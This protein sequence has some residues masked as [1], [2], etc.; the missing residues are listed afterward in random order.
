M[1]YLR[2]RDL[3]NMKRKEWIEGEE[4][5]NLFSNEDPVQNWSRTK[6]RL[7][8]R[9]LTTTTGYRDRMYYRKPKVRRSDLEYLSIIMGTPVSYNFRNERWEKKRVP[10]LK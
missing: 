1:V 2:E 10:C 9:V 6:D 5:S 3:K 7:Y 4:G 8:T